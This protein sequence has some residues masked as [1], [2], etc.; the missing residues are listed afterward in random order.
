MKKV[1]KLVWILGGCFISS[2][3]GCFA[4]HLIYDLVS[5]PDGYLYLD[6]DTKNIYAQLNEDPDNYK[7]GSRLVFKYKK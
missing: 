7:N 2:L 6:R 3:G 1:P 4:G 5:K